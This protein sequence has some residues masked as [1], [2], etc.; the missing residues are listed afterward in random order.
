MTTPKAQAACRMTAMWL[1]SKAIPGTLKTLEI[2][3]RSFFP[4]IF[5]LI[6]V[7]GGKRRKL[8]ISWTESQRFQTER[9]TSDRGRSS[10][11]PRCPKKC[12]SLRCPFQ[13]SVPPTR[14]PAS[15]AKYRTQCPS[16]HLK[17][18]CLLSQC[19]L[20]WAKSPESHIHCTQDTRLKLKRPEAKKRKIRIQIPKT[21][22]SVSIK[23]FPAGVIFM[24][25]LSSAIKQCSACS[26]V[27]RKDS[28]TQMQLSFH[29][30][31]VLLSAW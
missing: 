20:H 6:S 19:S 4:C 28:V 27:I 13:L 3:S 23:D 1:S 9:A 22:I 12:V 16:R 15:A 26:R 18:V 5:C 17:L 2:A 14:V 24:W 11:V 8:I 29:K 25:A 7:L 21:I 30:M 10:H 31:S